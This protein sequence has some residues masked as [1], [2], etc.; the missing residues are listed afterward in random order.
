MKTEALM[1]KNILCAILLLSL[2]AS[3]CQ[4]ATTPVA[5]TP[6][7][8]TTD[9]KRIKNATL[10]ITV[11]SHRAS[12]LIMG[13]G[14]G[15]L[16]RH[17]SDVL[18]V[19]HN[20]WRD[21]LQDA[22]IVNLYDADNRLLTRRF[23]FE[24]KRYILFQDAGTLVLQA[25]E[26]LVGLLAPVSLG[27]EVQLQLGA[28]VQVACRQQPSGDRLLVRQARVEEISII[29]GV[30]VY[31]LHSLDGQA[32]QPGDSGGGVW[33]AGELIANIWSVIATYS[34]EDAFGTRDST[35]KNFTDLSYAAVFPLNFR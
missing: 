11:E 10:L 35:S 7:L 17:E 2:V 12:G 30:S 31:K 24:L 23:V 18:L 15:T 6:T 28:R 1:K 33:Y 14:I 13:Y 32:L 4:A 21:F 3:A 16:V 22:N 8:T 25:P 9:V 34:V 20:H 26:E 27:P 5:I 19:T 29:Q